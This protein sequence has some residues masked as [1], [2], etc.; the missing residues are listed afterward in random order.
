MNIKIVIATHKKYRMPEDDIYIPLHVGAEGKYDKD[1]KPLDLGYIRDNTGDN[2]SGLNAGFCELTGLYW[3][4]KNLDA[5]HI[6]LVHYRRYFSYKKKGTEPFDNILTGEEAEKIFSKY[7]MIVPAKRHYYIETIYSHYAHTHYASQLDKTR[8][9]IEKS[10]PD[11]LSDYDKVIKRTWGY[12]FNMA[13]MSRDML[14]DYCT[15]LFGI[16][17][18]LKSQV[19]AGKVENSTGLSPFQSRFYGR[20][21][22]ALFNVWLAHQLKAGAVKH[23]KELKCISMEKIDW[24]RKARSF[25]GA[26]FFG[27]K[28]ESSF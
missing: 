2:I 9:I 12:M 8:E 7:D 16:L 15:W 6:G 21:S 28:Y 20:I 10:Y 23:I 4:W 24:K 26:K 13:V 27:R 11:Y 5:D 1:G 3:A 19:D 17:F 14:N 25:L 22:E 18:E